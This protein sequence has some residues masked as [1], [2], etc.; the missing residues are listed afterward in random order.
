MPQI[1]PN[2]YVE[3]E[4]LKT[5]ADNDLRIAKTRQA[6][7]KAFFAMICEM[8]YQE[9][10]VREL[11]ARARIN[12]KTFYAHYLT[13]DDLRDEMQKDLV[14]GFIKRTSSFRKLKDMAVITREFFLYAADHEVIKQH[15]LC[16][17]AYHFVAD[18]IETILYAD[19]HCSSGF[20][21]Y[22]KKIIATFL[23]AS[24][25][26]TY[27]QW[28]KDGKKVPVEEIIKIASGLVSYGVASLRE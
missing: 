14:A 26:E 7:Q 19:R 24:I 9:I 25:L 20:T 11:T 16:D 10:T 23:S 2:C 22:T 17:E 4:K 1:Y 28:I 12:R 18:K 5:K 21:N 6:I 3:E 15:I 8:E 13:L 27:R